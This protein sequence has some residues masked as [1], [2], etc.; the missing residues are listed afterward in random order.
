MAWIRSSGQATTITREVGG[1]VTVAEGT[2]VRQRSGGAEM[3][4]AM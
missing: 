2:R 4:R 1:A 3:L